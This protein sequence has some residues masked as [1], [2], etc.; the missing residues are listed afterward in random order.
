MNAPSP[1]QRARGLDPR[2]LLLR[3]DTPRLRNRLIE[4]LPVNRRCLAFAPP[5]S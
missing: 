3:E 4:P 1:D 5:R 2:R